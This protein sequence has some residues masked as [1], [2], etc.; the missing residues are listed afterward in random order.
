MAENILVMGVGNPLARDEG[1]GTAVIGLLE[2]DYAFP[3]NV[4]LVDAG[5]MGMKI[6]NLL[7]DVDFLLVVDA[8]Q[9]TGEAPGTVVGLSPEDIAPNQ[10]L[11]SLH[12]MRLIDVLQAAELLD[13]RPAEAVF[14]GVEV[15][16]IEMMRPGL[17]PVVEAAVPAAA[18]AMLGALASRGVEWTRR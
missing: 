15:A 10:V 16:E 4:R 5:T 1:V 17:T 12:D 2:R 14:V 6:I 9:G 18:E 8:V 11:H 3:E 13:M 7:R